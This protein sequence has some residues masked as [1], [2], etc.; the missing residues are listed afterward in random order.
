MPVAGL[1]AACCSSSSLWMFARCLRCSGVTRG[2]GVKLHGSVSPGQLACR[3]LL[4]I[5]SLERDLHGLALPAAGSSLALSSLG[6]ALSSIFSGVSTLARALPSPRGD[7]IESPQ[8]SPSS[9]K[10]LPP[11][12]VCGRP[13]VATCGRCGKDPCPY[14]PPYTDHDLKNKKF[15]TKFI[16]L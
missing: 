12:T 6:S 8:S 7:P 2:G 3:S 16:V 13:S 9:K 15:L 5:G 14:P 1:S 11:C 4:E 10:N